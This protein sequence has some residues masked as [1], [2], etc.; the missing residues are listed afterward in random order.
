MDDFVNSFEIYWPL[1]DFYSLIFHEYLVKIEVFY[2]VHYWSQVFNQFWILNLTIHFFF[3]VSKKCPLN[4]SF[5]K[6][7]STISPL[8]INKSIF[9]KK[10]QLQTEFQP[11][12]YYLLT[13]LIRKNLTNHHASSKQKILQTKMLV[14]CQRFADMFLS[15]LVWQYST[16][17]NQY[18][19]DTFKVIATYLQH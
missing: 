18:N 10:I 11:I 15:G 6:Q 9:E 5:Y 13:Y 4:C 12:V 1:V 16:N 3:K 8:K 7:K 17:Q 2:L 19:K 14:T